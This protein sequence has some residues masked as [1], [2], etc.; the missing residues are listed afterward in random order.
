MRTIDQNH[1]VDQAEQVIRT[2]QSRTRERRD[3]TS[4]PRAHGD[5]VED[6]KP[7][8]AALDCRRWACPRDRFRNGCAAGSNTCGSVL[9]TKRERIRKAESGICDG[10]RR[11]WTF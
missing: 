11:F 1:Y 2:L 10:R 6:P 3:G 5:H 8:D 4:G 7:A 9:S